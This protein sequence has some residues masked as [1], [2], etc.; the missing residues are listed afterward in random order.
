M[1]TKI[2]RLYRELI[3]IQKKEMKVINQDKIEHF[4]NILK[5]YLKTKKDISETYFDNNS[6]YLILLKIENF[7]EKNK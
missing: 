7:V 4:I 2:S 1:L 3:S 6:F 5:P